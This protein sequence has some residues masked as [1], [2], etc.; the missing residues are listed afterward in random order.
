VNTT[1]KKKININKTSSALEI[2]IDHSIEK[3]KL[4][5][6]G[7]WLTLW[8]ICGL[9]I[10]TSFFFYPKEGK[11]MIVVFLTFWA[12]FEAMVYKA[13][14]WKKSGMEKLVV[15]DKQV[16]ITTYDGREKT[17]TIEADKIK[18]VYLAPESKFRTT[19]TGSFWDIGESAIFIKTGGRN[20]GFGKQLSREE[21]IKIEKLLKPLERPD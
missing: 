18:S 13:F 7:M 14:R 1:D 10:I 9:I 2:I 8:T 3:K 17:I 5:M 20:I 12:Y 19:M 4:N 6:I 15:K 16:S 21:A 11:L